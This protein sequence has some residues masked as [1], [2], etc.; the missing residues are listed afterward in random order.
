M[1]L[2]NHDLRDETNN[3]V[4]PPKPT[5]GAMQV[6]IAGSLHRGFHVRRPLLRGDVDGPK[7]ATTAEQFHNEWDDSG[8]GP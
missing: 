5:T 1:D 6:V 3:D 4:L 2:L 7:G 8:W